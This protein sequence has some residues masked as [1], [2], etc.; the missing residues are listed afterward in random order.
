MNEHFSGVNAGTL[1]GDGIYFAEDM[2][3]SDQYCQVAVGA[4]Q[5]ELRSLLGK[6]A[7]SGNDVRYVFVARV[8]LGCMVPVGADRSKHL[9]TKE[10]AFSAGARELDCVFL[11]YE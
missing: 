4:A 10:P 5:S 7:P 2:G 1:F 11:F 6:S 9:L 3:K 8:V